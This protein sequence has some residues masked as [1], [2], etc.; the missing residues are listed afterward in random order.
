M[1]CVMAGKFTPLYQIVPPPPI[2]KWSVLDIILWWHFTFAVILYNEAARAD[3]SPWWWRSQTIMGKDEV[4][5]TWIFKDIDV[6]PSLL[7]GD[8]W[9]GNAGTVDRNPGYIMI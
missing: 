2:Y 5:N 3:R 6:K 1:G 9:S 7:H 4:H 8:L